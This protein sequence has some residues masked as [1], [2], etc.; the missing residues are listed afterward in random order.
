VRN[1][2]RIDR[3][4]DGIREVWKKPECQDMR[5]GQL[6]INMGVVENGEHWFVEDDVNERMIGIY[7]ANVRRRRKVDDRRKV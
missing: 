6:L 4:L 5:L 7:S 1:P 2:D 3:I